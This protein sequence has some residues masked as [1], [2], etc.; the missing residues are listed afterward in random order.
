MNNSG[1]YQNPVFP[2]MENNN[3]MP[4]QEFGSNFGNMKSD[5][6]YGE[7]YLDGFLKR[8]KGKKVKVYTTIPGSNEWQDKIFEGIIEETGKD[9]IILSDPATGQWHIIPM[10]FFDFIT[11]VEPINTIKNY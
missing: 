1:Y 3:N 4:N 7:S 5:F 6:T 8:N 9:Y 11:F 10:M 2:G